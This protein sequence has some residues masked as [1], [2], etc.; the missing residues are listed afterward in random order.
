MPA[1]NDG[2][3]GARVRIGVFG[4]CGLVVVVFV[5]AMITREYVASCKN[6]TKKKLDG[7]GESIMVYVRKKLKLAANVSRLKPRVG[8]T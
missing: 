3:S 6:D 4:L 1:T 2:V 8:V 5:E 7:Q